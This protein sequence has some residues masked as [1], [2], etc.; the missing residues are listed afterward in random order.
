MRFSFY[1]AGELCVLLTSEQW[2]YELS[3]LILLFVFLC[4]SSS[5]L[6]FVRSENVQVLWMKRE[7][8]E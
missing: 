4:V 1:C 6:L 5:S 3:P 2:L 8:K 7:Y